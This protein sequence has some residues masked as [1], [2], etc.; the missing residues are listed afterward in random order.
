VSTLHLRALP[1]AAEAGDLL[2]QLA[3]LKPR[4]ST[5]VR[6]FSWVALEGAPIQN[7]T[8]SDL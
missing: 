6:G 7:H 3:R 4:P 2:P 1:T 5:V 8:A